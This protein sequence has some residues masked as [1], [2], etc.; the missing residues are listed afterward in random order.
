MSAQPSIF[1]IDF[2]TTNSLLAAASAGCCFEPAPLDP[3][4]VDPTILRSALHFSSADDVAFG[5]AALR[6]FVDSGLR[7]RLLRSIKRHLGSPSFEATRIG[8]SRRTIEELAGTFLREMRER[9]CRHYGKDID[10]V[11]LGRPARF[12]ERAEDDDLAVLRLGEAARLAG[13][14]EIWFCFEPVAAAYDFA[15]NFERSRTVL[16]ADLGGGTSDF[17]VV[18]MQPEAFTPDDVLAVG[19]VS[20][21]GDA[22]DGAMVRDLVAPWFG[23]T[24]AYRLPAGTNV[25]T[26]P[27][28]LLHLLCSPARLTLANERAVLE[29]LDAIR[30]GLLDDADLVGLNRFATLVGDAVGYQFYES[31][32]AAKVA[33]SASDQVELSF[34]YPGIDLERPVSRAEFDTAI[35]WRLDQILDALDQ[36]LLDA[37]LASDAIE[38]VCLTGGTSMVPVVETAIRARLPSAQVVRLRSH[39]SV[40]QGLARCARSLEEGRQ[41][42]GLTQHHRS[43]PTAPKPRARRVYHLF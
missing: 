36:T 43:L 32:E 23:S 19:G 11:V 39:H 10:R 30:R 6:R 18:R 33:L 27:G 35:A 20:T 1:A 15:S 22:I 5:Q 29:N 17:T 41:T 25:L 2:G 34:D 4:A 40:V 26:M 8:S 31:I 37:Q 38:I 21:A 42:A 14:R 12:S 24:A 16:I 3:L 9:A 7:G 13:F 28:E